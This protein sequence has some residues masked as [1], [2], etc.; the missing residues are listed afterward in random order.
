[1]NYRRFLH[2]AKFW[3]WVVLFVAYSAGAVGLV[4][5]DTYDD[6][7]RSLS[8]VQLTSVK[9]DADVRRAGASQVAAVYRA[10]SGMPFA[11]LPAGSTFQVV[12]PDGS[13]ETM[14]IMDPTSSLGVEPVR[15]TQITAADRSR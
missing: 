5:I 13:T 1:M 8:K 9:A 2:G 15:N 7:Y 14:V 4:M 12:W 6:R 10:Q 11:S 3:F